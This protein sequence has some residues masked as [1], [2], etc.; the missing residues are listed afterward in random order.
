MA[1]TDRAMIAAIRGV[2]A[3]FDWE[4]DDRQYALEQIERIM[5]PERARR[6]ELI[7]GLRDLADYLSEHESIPVP[8]NSRDLLVFTDGDSN[9]ARRA[10]VDA[11]AAEFGSETW[12]TASETPRP[13]YHTMI[14]FGPVEYTV[15]TIDA[16]PADT[17]L[18]DDETDVELGEVA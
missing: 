17:P 18:A 9:D 8:V 15:L 13:H 14:S 6:A 2:L 10:A 1:D 3:D 16:P 11:A 7:K 12:E 4:S 5:D